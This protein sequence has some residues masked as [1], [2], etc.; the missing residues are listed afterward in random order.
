MDS[1]L[2]SCRG[3]PARENVDHALRES[4]LPDQVT[5][6]CSSHGGLLGG[7]QDRC[8]SCGHCGSNLPGEH[9]QR[10]IPRND[11]ANNADRL[12]T[13]ERKVFVRVH[14]QRDGFPLDLICPPCVVSENIGHQW[15]V[16]VSG[17][18]SGFSVVSGFDI[19]Q[20]VCVLHHQVGEAVEAVASEGRV[21]ATPAVE[22]LVGSLHGS[23]DVCLSS[24]LDG[25]IHLLSC[26]VDRVEG[27]THTIAEFVVDE[28]AR[29]HREFADLN[30][31]RGRECASKAGDAGSNGPPGRN[32]GR[33]KRAHL[34]I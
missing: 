7:L 26:R 23:V 8:A 13:S 4:R 9:R 25:G 33:N 16:D 34:P 27:C 32:E 21:G 28:Q 5:H 30:A 19:C 12:V 20:L 10:K 6:H 14:S 24:L 29:L 2:M 15:N 17:D 3:A 31:T 18:V 11:L 1:D 22:R